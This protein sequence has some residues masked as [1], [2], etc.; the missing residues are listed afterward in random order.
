MR[1]VTVYK[2]KCQR[3]VDTWQLYISHMAVTAL[4]SI[5]EQH[6]LT[7]FGISSC[8]DCMHKRIYMRVV[9]IAHKMH[10]VE[11]LYIT[12]SHTAVT[13]LASINKQHS[14]HLGSLPQNTACMRE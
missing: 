2:H 10:S 9:D 12:S 5:N 8:E 3:K 14:H 13:A 7:V 1:V 11:H 4:A 6:A